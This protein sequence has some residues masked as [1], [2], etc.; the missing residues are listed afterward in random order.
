M[1]PM[2][3]QARVYRALELLQEAQWLLDDAGQALC[4]V[5]GA[6][7]V[8]CGTTA[9][10]FDIKRQWHRV[11]QWYETHHRHDGSAS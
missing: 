4:S 1:M 8:W 11:Q 10:Y 2:S 3:D 6:A 5:D 9:L 7:D